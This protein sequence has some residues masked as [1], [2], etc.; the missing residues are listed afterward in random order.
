MS[1]GPISIIR[2]LVDTSYPGKDRIVGNPSLDIN[3]GKTF[4]KI[5]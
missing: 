4:E 2:Q 5:E 3:N 1:M